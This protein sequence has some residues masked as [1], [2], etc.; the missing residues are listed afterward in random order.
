MPPAGLPGACSAH[1]GV[2]TAVRAAAKSTLDRSIAPSDPPVSLHVKEPVLRPAAPMASI[3]LESEVIQLF[4]GAIVTF[5]FAESGRA[6]A[7]KGPGQCIR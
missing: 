7:Q 6:E 3:R 5:S 1:A 2:A 4:S